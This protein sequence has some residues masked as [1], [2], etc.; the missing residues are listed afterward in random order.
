MVQGGEGD[1]EAP[2]GDDG[3]E[4]GGALHLETVLSQARGAGPACCAR[5]PVCVWMCV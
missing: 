5:A 4:D 2:P 3:L 1:D